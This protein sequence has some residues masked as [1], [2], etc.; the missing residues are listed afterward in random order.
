[1]YHWLVLPPWR[2]LGN[3]SSSSR[4]MGKTGSFFSIHPKS[5]VYYFHVSLLPCF[6]W[7]QDYRKNSQ[8]WCPNRYL[9]ELSS[10]YN[11]TLLLSPR[12]F[13]SS[14]RPTHLQ[15]AL[16]HI[17]SWMTANLLTLNASKTELFLIGLEKQI[18]KIDSSSLNTPPMVVFL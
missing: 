9:S 15:N 6:W 17:S 11:S 10:C 16:Q 7:Q 5:R 1:M 14:I 18:A 2:T 4:P 8:L 3:I 12:N 13:D